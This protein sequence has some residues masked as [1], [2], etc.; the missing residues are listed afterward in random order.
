MDSCGE[1]A[2]GDGEGVAKLP[3]LLA[4]ADAEDL[5]EEHGGPLT[6]VGTS[7]QKFQ[8][9]SETPFTLPKH[10]TRSENR[11][12]AAER[13]ETSEGMRNGLVNSNY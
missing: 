4:A 11:G 7:L 8:N 6:A 9:T 5:A 2:H 3:G 1:R 10:P 13:R 12:S